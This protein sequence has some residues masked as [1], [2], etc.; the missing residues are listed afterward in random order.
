MN[1]IFYIQT[2]TK[3]PYKLIITFWVCLAKQSFA[4]VTIYFSVATAFM[5]YCDVKYS[6]TFWDPAMFAVV[7]SPLLSL[8]LFRGLKL[9]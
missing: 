8:L 5:F 4:C 1:F 9:G 3:V 6:V 2:S 7:C